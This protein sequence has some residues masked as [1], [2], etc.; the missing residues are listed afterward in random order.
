MRR[1]VSPGFLLSFL[2]A[3]SLAWAEEDVVMKAMRDELTRSMKQLQ[4]EN[5]EK[6]Y[7]IA[8]RVE[9]TNDARVSATFGSLLI[10]NENHRRLLTVEVRVG[11]YALDNTNF[12][13]MNFGPAGVVHSFGG[14]LQLPLENDYGEIRRQIWLAT[15]SAYKKAVED[16]ARKRAALENKT[17]PEELPDFSKEQPTTITEPAAPLRVDLDK[18]EILVRHLSGLFGEM[19]QISV[20]SVQ[21][22]ASDLDM[23]Y[24]NSE[25]TVLR[26]TTPSV[27]LRVFAATQAS[28]GMPLND[29]V[30]A[31]ARS[32]K[33]LPEAGELDAQV[34]AMGTRLEKLRAAALPERY[35]GPVL[36]EGQAA[37]ELF[38]QGMAPRLVALRRPVS[39]NPQ[40]EMFSG[41]I[42]NP[43]QNRL[44]TRV[45]PEFMGIVDDPTITE[46]RKIPLLGGY[47]VDNDGVLARP[48]TL[49]ENGVL[50]TLLATRDPVPGVLHSTGN[51]RGSSPVPSNLILTVQNGLGKKEMKEKLLTLMKR[52]GKEYGVVVRRMG[53]PFL[54][55]AQGIG[56]VLMEFFFPGVAGQGAASP[57]AIL[58]YKV[59]LD[60]REELIRNAELE[61]I[62]PASF[63]EIL[64]ASE[65]HIVYTSPFM[66]LGGALFSF[67]TSGNAPGDTRAPNVSYVVPSLLFDEVTVR[68]RSGEIPRPPIS[69]HPHFDR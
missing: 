9:E 49:V 5:L 12:L 27:V 50:K 21:L 22:E 3:V 20:S 30:T 28:D 25:G 34:R 29:F 62:S 10:R 37:A 39:D 32:L 41:H 47:K 60:G 1:A 33:E 4:V 58:A 59:Y 15:D 40:F 42:E 11:D 8:Y 17:R 63:K 14:S 51:R 69:K 19:P 23:R 36:F 68:P 67:L 44:G 48:T 38:S 53:N 64:S 54:P 52:R 26:R 65:E 56:L 61:G 13:S 46:Y 43:F 24:I 66:P 16:L 31:H 57:R 45:L 7:F 18:A 2:I 55:E 6:P 35:T